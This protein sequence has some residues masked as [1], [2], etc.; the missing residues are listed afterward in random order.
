MDITGLSISIATGNVA[1]I[2]L[3]GLSLLYDGFAT[4]IPILPAGAGAARTAY[5]A[6]EVTKAGVEQVTKFSVESLTKGLGKEWHHAIPKFLGGLQQQLKFY[7]PKAQHTAFHKSLYANLKAAGMPMA[8]LSKEAIADMFK[9]NAGM[10]DKSWNVL[11]DTAR[12]FDK[13]NGTNVVGAIWNS[14]MSGTKLA[15]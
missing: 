5:R 13:E 10:M 14:I 7:L 12:Q 4:A 15:E 3:D 8:G 11:L 6:A 1:G 2:V 9:N